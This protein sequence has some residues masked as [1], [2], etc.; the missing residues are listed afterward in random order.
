[1]KTTILFLALATW[2]VTARCDALLQN[3]FGDGSWLWVWDYTAGGPAPVMCI[4]D[5]KS[6]VLPAS[7]PIIQNGDL[8]VMGINPSQ[9]AVAPGNNINS[10][11]FQGFGQWCYTGQIYDGCVYDAYYYWNGN[12]GT[13]F[14]EVINT[15]DEY[16]TAS[17]KRAFEDAASL[18]YAQVY[19]EGLAYGLPL[20]AA[21]AG[22]SIIRSIITEK[23]DI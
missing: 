6:I 13:Q 1:M 20:W 14:P 4:P 10:G 7:S 8:I 23:E 21:V 9:Y 16:G 12:V 19:F 11:S 3:T 15:G 22:F 2:Q 5:G 18:P 17:D